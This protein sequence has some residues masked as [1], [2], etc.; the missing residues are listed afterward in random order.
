MVFL[1]TTNTIISS[2]HPIPVFSRFSLITAQSSCLREIVRA[3]SRH[4][5]IALKRIEAIRSLV[6]P[7][8]F[9]PL[10][11][12][13]LASH[14]HLSGFHRV[15]PS[16]LFRSS[17]CSY[18]L[19]VTEPGLTM[20][21]HGLCLAKMEPTF[22]YQLRDNHVAPRICNPSPKLFKSLTL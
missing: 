4:F 20:I 21:R 13:F 3:C 22:P 6:D 8:I 11:G 16:F 5:G 15:C 18:L 12:S 1:L 17:M 10:H 14:V 19:P 2:S 9:P 7:S